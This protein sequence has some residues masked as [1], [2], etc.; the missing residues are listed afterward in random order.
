MYEKSIFPL[1]Q[2]STLDSNVDN[3]VSYGS[4]LF[5]YGNLDL[6]Y[7]VLKKAVEMDSTNEK[8]MYFFGLVAAWVCTS[9]LSFIARLAAVKKLNLH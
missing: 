5:D 3:L 7:T 1:R 8:A 9:L 6:S 4:A 2:C